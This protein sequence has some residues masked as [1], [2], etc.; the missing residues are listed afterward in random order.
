[1][2]RVAVVGPGRMGTLFATAAVRAGYRLTAVAGGST[3]SREA[4]SRVVSGVRY[5]DSVSRAAGEADL[6]V[7]AVPDDVIEDVVTDLVRDD[8]LGPDHRVIHL[9]G[10]RGVAALH[11]A[12]LAGAG[13]AAC[14]P[15]VTAPSGSS[16]PQVLVGAPWA[17]TAAPADRGWAHELVTRLGGDVHEVAE[18][19]RVLYHAAMVLAANAVGAAVTTARQLLL[20]AEVDAPE[21]FVGPLAHASVVNAAARGASVLTGPLVRGD[22]GTIRRHLNGIDGDVAVLGEPY[23]LLMRATLAQVRA[24]LDPGVA[25]EL[26]AALAESPGTHT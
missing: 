1:M 5:H 9:A 13:V 15:A 18:D 26:D 22:V 24:A 2:M 20:A 12:S 17:V 25:A 8:A 6:V 3:A 7:L 10:S 14:H 21:V 11:R 23:R 4:F 19:R 16:D